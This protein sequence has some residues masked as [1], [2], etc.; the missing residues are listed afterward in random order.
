MNQKIL[1]VIKIPYLEQEFDILIPKNKKI[2]NIKNEIIKII[3]EMYPDIFPDT[4]QLSLYERITGNLLQNEKYPKNYI[5]N[6]SHLI[7]I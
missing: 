5:K 6:G 2:G 1:V 7:L 3:N 4:N